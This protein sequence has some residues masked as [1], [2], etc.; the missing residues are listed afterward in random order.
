[1]SG[2]NRARLIRQTLTI[3]RR[4]FTAT[5]FTPLFLL[6]LLSP[7]IMIAFASIGAV[8]G[9]TLARGS[10][11]KVQIIAIAGPDQAPALIAA[12]KRLR[13][14]VRRSD[15]PPLKIETPSADPKAQARAAFDGRD[16]DVAAVLY[17][18]LD[19]P[20]ILYGTAG[21]RASDYLATLADTVLRDQKL[22]DKPLSVATKTSIVRTKASRSGR[23]QSAFL[24][25]TGIFFLTLFLSGQAV[26]TMAEER[27]NKVIEILAAAVPLESVF[28]GKLL[29]MF[30]VAVLFVTFWG[31][32][33][34]QVGRL[35]PGGGA[36][37]AELA[38]AVGMPV[39]VLLFCGY[40][41]M[42]YMLLGAV[43]LS[44]G[45]QAQTMRE[46]QMLSLPIT[47]VQMAM[48][49]LASAA[50]ADP[51]STIATIAEVFPLSSPFA[52]AA[53]AANKPEIW[54]HLLALAWQGLWV[55]ITIWIGAGAFRRGV[56]KSGSGRKGLMARFVRR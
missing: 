34:S 26:G 43:F 20:Q 9:A 42:A 23:N 40:F 10:G 35:L 16:T 6:F 32:L 54:P 3:A 21:V 27:S 53:H 5:V 45:A 51:G 13:Q 8:G 25:V 46:I 24:A 48:F 49:G 52:M 39:F 33:L 55:A 14:I 2:S 41:T 7:M 18:P 47:I 44:V 38:P 31:T 4:D 12:D 36:A 19:R 22:G 1:M 56:L 11:D 30:G 50:A 15:A 17:G 29:G 37:L 28:L